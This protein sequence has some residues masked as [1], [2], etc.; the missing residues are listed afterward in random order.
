MSC[1]TSL[2][3]VPL[4]LNADELAKVL[5]V[6]PPVAYELMRTEGFPTLYIGKRMI[7]FKPKFLEWIDQ[8]TPV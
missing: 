3:Q 6:S 1:Y 7:V 4:S 5:H 2:D 8:Q